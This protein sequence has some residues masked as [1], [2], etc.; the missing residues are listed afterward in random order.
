[1]NREERIEFLN[2]F[3]NQH[4]KL[5]TMKGLAEAI[6]NFENRTNRKF[7]NNF[8]INN[9]VEFGE[10]IGLDPGVKVYIAKIYKYFLF[11]WKN[12]EKSIFGIFETKTELQLHFSNMKN[13]RP[14]VIDFW[15]DMVEQIA[16]YKNTNELFS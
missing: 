16:T 8:D 1:M 14:D 3:F 7:P 10:E 11:G 4:S 6:V 12:E 9:L 13:M 5:S 15:T 2:E